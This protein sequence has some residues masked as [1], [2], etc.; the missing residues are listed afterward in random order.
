MKSEAVKK[1]RFKTKE[2]IINTMGGKCVCC[3][4]ANSPWVLELH[5]IDPKNKKFSFGSIRAN[6]KNWP[7]LVEE[8]KNCILV[9]A[10]CHR[11]IH[12]GVREIPKN[13]SIFNEQYSSYKELRP[14]Q[15][16]NCGKPKKHNYGFC[17]N[18]CAGKAKQKVNWKEIDLNNL[19]NIKKLTYTAIGK[20]LGVS[21]NAVRKHYKKI[22]R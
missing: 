9:C 4:Y 21:D 8:L 7:A 11:E 12:H 19:I 20:M 17:S 5:H 14:V 22:P 15:F 2:R 10:N 3:G 6:P 1:W 18:I 16:C 13:Y